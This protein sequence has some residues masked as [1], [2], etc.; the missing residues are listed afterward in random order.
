MQ[1]VKDV[2]AMREMLDGDLFDLQCTAG[3]TVPSIKFKFED[4][5]KVIRSICLHFLI[6]SVKSELD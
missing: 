2:V 6:H 1:N 5:P 4:V 3:I